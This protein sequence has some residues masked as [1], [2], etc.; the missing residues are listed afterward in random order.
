MI[1]EE[2]KTE[3]IDWRW[4]NNVERITIFAEECNLV[5]TNIWAEPHRGM[6]VKTHY[7]VL[8]TRQGIANLQ[9]KLK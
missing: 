3:K 2:L 1:V 7:T 4:K 5:V 6:W 8:G 9:R